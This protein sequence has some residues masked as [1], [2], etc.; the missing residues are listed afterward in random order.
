MKWYGHNMERSTRIFGHKY[1]SFLVAGSI[2]KVLKISWIFM[3]SF[4]F[5]KKIYAN[6]SGIIGWKEN[7][8]RKENKKK[9]LH[10]QATTKFVHLFTH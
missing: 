9:S 6:N 8:T 7:A 10:I 2:Q 5:Q 4:C 1:H 3:A